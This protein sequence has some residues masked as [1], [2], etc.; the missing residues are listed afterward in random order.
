MAERKTKKIEEVISAEDAAKEMEKIVET[1]EKARDDKEKLILIENAEK[2][3]KQKAYVSPE[4]RAK[5]DALD[6]WVPKTELGRQVLSKKIKNIDEILD[7]GKKILEPEIVDTL[8]NVRTELLNVG[9][10]KGKFGGGKRRNW[11]QTQKKTEEG[12]VL[13]FSVLAIVGDGNGYVGMG[14]GRASETLPA[15]EKAIKKAKMNIIKIKRG[16]A[17][18][19]CSCKENHSI[20][21]V[22]SGK[23]SSVVIKLS[24]A[25]QGTGLVVGDEIKKILRLAGIQDVYGRSRGKTRTTINVAKATFAA[26]QKLDEVKE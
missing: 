3:D 10:A 4:E 13:T 11:R 14:F 7:S 15:K 26:L 1:E 12:N 20:P 23:C 16:C 9:Q 22:A 5:K 19:D 17:S 8:L 21:T 6:N 25:P 18:Y 24:P 2:S